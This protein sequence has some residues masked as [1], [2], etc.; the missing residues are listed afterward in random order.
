M[1]EKVNQAWATWQIAVFWSLWL[2]L[3]FPAY[4]AA[5]GVWLIGM[6]MF[7]GF[8]E[9]VDVVLL[10]I[11]VAS[12]LLL[13]FIAVRLVLHFHRHTKS[14]WRLLTGLLVGLLGV[15]LLS[16]SSAVYAYVSLVN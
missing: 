6:P 11:M 15:P 10:G 5:H 3:L 13:A 9:T 14:F 2:L 12:L 7:A 1:T 16:A 8:H 4:F